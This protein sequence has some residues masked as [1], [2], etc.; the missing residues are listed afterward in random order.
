MK[1]R[2]YFSSTGEV[3]T[4]PISRTVTSI[5]SFPFGLLMEQAVEA[6]SP[7]HVPFSSSPLV[8]IR[9]IARPRRESGHSS[10]NSASFPCTFDH[11]CKGESFIS[12]HLILKDPLESPQVSYNSYPLLPIIYSILLGLFSLI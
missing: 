6:N 11:I 9:D 5:W 8:G 7:V 10:Q 1:L 12:T 3:V 2:W 4:I